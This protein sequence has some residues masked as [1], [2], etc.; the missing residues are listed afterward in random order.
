M[1][2]ADRQHLDDVYYA[3]CESG[4]EEVGNL[5]DLLREAVGLFTE[6]QSQQFFNGLAGSL[7]ARYSRPQEEDYVKGFPANGL[8]CSICYEPQF[9]TFSGDSCENGH[10]GAPGL[11]TDDAPGCMEKTDEQP[12]NRAV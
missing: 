3:C 9:F 2:E 10:G 7:V 12:N 8:V 6:E 5:Q 11:E 4:S 1:R